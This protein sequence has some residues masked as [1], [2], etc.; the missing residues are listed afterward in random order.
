MRRL[1]CFGLNRG[2]FEFSWKKTKNA[3]GG[4]PNLEH[5]LFFFNRKA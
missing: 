1:N 4:V 5:D 2:Q 3:I